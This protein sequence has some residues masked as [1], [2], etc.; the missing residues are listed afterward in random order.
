LKDMPGVIHIVIHIVIP[1]VVPALAGRRAGT[2]RPASC[3]LG[4]GPG[5]LAFLTSLSLGRTPR[6][7]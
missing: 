1:A 7:G 5:S 2:H 6:P 3:N 4:M